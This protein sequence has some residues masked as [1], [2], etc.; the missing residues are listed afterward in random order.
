MK[1][2][3]EK[4]GVGRGFETDAKNIEQARATLGKADERIETLE[5]EL[6]KKQATI[7]RLLSDDALSSEELAE[8]K[9]LVWLFHLGLP[10]SCECEICAEVEQSRRELRRIIPG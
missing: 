5:S 2:N 4:S 6:R 1:A 8:L 7:R 3:I 9:E 10:D